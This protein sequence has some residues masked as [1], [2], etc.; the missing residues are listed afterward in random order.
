MVTG[1]IIREGDSEFH[2]PTAQ[3]VHLFEVYVIQCKHHST[4]SGPE[5]TITI[6]MCCPD[7]AAAMVSYGTQQFFA[8]RFMKSQYF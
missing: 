3:Q 6:D 2:V 7:I 1:A 4:I 8:V 5:S